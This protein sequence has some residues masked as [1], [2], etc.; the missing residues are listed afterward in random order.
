MLSNDFGNSFDNY[1]VFVGN[2]VVDDATSFF[3]LGAELKS[4][5]YFIPKYSLFVEICAI[6]FL[7]CFLI[8]LRRDDEFGDLSWIF[9]NQFF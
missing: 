3:S 2:W 6:D 4:P 8:I 9:I 7:N 1:F 5:N